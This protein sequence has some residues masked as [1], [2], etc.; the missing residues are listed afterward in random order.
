MDPHIEPHKN[1]QHILQENE[2]ISQ[3]FQSKDRKL[4]RQTLKVLVG[5]NT[6]CK[7]TCREK[8]AIETIIS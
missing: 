3:S 5:L 2:Q 6:K 8:C 7:R 4:L 1:G